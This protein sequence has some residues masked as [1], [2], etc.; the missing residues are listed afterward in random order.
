MFTGLVQEIG[1]IE[2]VSDGAVRRIDVRIGKPEPAL[3]LGESIAVDGVC[4]TVT[5][6]RGGR[7][8]V[9][10]VEETLRRST[11]GDLEKGGSVNIERSLR[12]GDRLGGHLVLGHVDAVSRI[13]SIRPEGDSRFIEVD[14][15]PGLA[16]FFVEKGSVCVD[17]ISL[18]VASLG[19]SAFGVALIPETLKR[20]TLGRKKVGDRVN[21]EADIIGKYVARLAGKATATAPKIDEAFLRQAGFA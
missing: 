2:G 16:P 5:K 8:S 18:T 17:G 20:T 15:P 7:F 11:L 19:A 4:L 10:A 13:A 21:L 14:L 12:L 9:E 3:E 1:S 6:A